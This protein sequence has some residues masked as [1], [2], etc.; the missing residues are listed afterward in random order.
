[1]TERDSDGSLGFELRQ[2]RTDLEDLA[3]AINFLPTRLGRLD[4]QLGHIRRQLERVEG[5]AADVDRAL[6]ELGA[7]VKRLNARVEWLER[8]IRLHEAGTLVVELDDV[9]PALGRL[10]AVAEVGLAVRAGLLSA[11]ER[12]GLHTTIEAR[13]GAIDD[14]DARLAEAL[15]ASVTIA[16]TAYGRT[17][18]REAITAFRAAVEAMRSAAGRADDL[19]AEAEEAEQRLAADEE[20]LAMRADV[21]ADGERAWEALLDHLRARIADAVGEGALLP[22]WFTSALG[23]IPPAEDTGPW[24]DAATEL[25][26]YRVTYEVSDPILALGPE[27]T[28]EEGEGGRRRGW[29][30]RL[31]RRL[32]ELQR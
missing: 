2:L 14:R 29:H 28:G 9:D 11:A 20:R 13:A 31:R 1:M 21:I 30:H 18:H 16:G 8:H 25:L 26:A 6:G 22:A 15:A 5:R 3:A 7:V 19:A 32:R 27:P 17:E 4:G 10:A 12:S 24:M 23:P